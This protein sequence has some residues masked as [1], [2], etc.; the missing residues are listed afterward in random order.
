MVFLFPFLSSMLWFCACLFIHHESVEVRIA[1][2]GQALV[3]F[4]PIPQTGE[5]KSRKVKSSAQCHSTTEWQSSEWPQHLPSSKLTL[6]PLGLTIHLSGVPHKWFGKRH[7]IIPCL[8]AHMLP[9]L[10]DGWR[11]QGAKR[12]RHP[13]SWSAPHS[14]AGCRNEW[15]GQGGI[16]S[17][18]R[19]LPSGWG[20]AVVS[21]VG[22]IR[23]GQRQRRGVTYPLAPGISSFTQC[24]HSYDS[25]LLPSSQGNRPWRRGHSTPLLGGSAGPGGLSAGRR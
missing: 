10:L 1:L 9:P 13:S 14:P 17:T 19:A 23:G 6:L 15:P 2:G 18:A 7:V 16:W 12:G 5:L 22:G 21:T 3:C 4:S 8:P 11:K 20:W 24:G 25:S